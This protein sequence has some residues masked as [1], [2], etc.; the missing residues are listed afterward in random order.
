MFSSQQMDWPESAIRSKR[1]RG[2][3]CWCRLIARKCSGF[4]SQFGTLTLLFHLPLDMNATIRRI[5]QLT[6]ILAPMAVGQ[7]MTFG[8]PVIGCGFISGW[9]LVSMCVEYFLL[10]KVYQKT[11]AL[12]VKAALKVEESELKQLTSPKGNGAQPPALCSK[13]TLRP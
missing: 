1:L 8:S 2:L 4:L 5:D 10:W 9:N 11:P 6:N 7:I 3:H 13:F 12:A